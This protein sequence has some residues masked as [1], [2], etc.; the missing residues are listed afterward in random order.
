MF[1]LMRSVSISARRQRDT[2]R[3]LVKSSQQEHV[4]AK[5]AF[6]R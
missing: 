6:R 1:L 3:F 4:R 2:T 5:T